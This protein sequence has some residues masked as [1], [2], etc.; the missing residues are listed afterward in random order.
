MANIKSR[1]SPKSPKKGHSATQTATT[2]SNA[3]DTITVM[4]NNLKLMTSD[5][6]K[7]SVEVKP[8][9]RIPNYFNFKAK[10]LRK[11]I[12]L[13]SDRGR[14]KK[15]YKEKLKLVND[16]LKSELLISGSDTE[17]STISTLSTTSKLPKKKHVHNNNDIGISDHNQSKNISNANQKFESNKNDK[18][19]KLKPRKEQKLNPKFQSQTSS[20]EQ[21]PLI[22][23]SVSLKNINL[24]NL[25]KSKPRKEQKINGKSQTQPDSIEQ[26]PAEKVSSS[27]ETNK[28]N[29]VAKSKPRKEQKANPKN[30]ASSIEDVPT[31]K[32]PK[33]IYKAVK[34]N[35]K[36]EKKNIPELQTQ[37]SSIR[38]PSEDIPGSLYE[39][40]HCSKTFAKKKLIERHMYGHL[41]LKPFKCSFCKKKFRYDINMQ[42]HVMRLHGTQDCDS[43]DEYRCDI[44]EEVF[45]FQETLNSHLKNHVRKANFF[46]CIVC[47]KKF[48][49]NYLLTEH[50]K[51]HLQNGRYQCPMCDMNYGIRNHFEAHLK[52]HS[53]IKDYIC[54]YCGKEFLR[55]NSMQRHVHV[56][57]SG[58]RFQCPICKK[59]LK[60]HLTE[61]MR[62]HDK[63]RPHECDVCGQR[64][65][66]STQLNVHM[67]SHTGAR[68]YPC[69]IC[70]RNFSHSNALMLHI[71]RH[72]GEKPFP[73]AMCPL[74]FS[75]LPHMK[76]HMKN[77][78]GKENAYKCEKCTQF[79][80]LKNDLERHIKTCAVG[81]KKSKRKRTQ[82]DQEDEEI[83]V[84]SVMTLS[85]MRYL[86]ALLL[87]I[88][89]TK[90]KLKYLGFNKRLID[91][92]LIES[93]EAMGIEPCMDESLTE[94]KRLKINIEMFI[95]G[96]VP[97]EELEK[98]KN[99][100][101]TTEEL[102]ELLTDEKKKQA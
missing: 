8:R 9:L 84:E 15:K 80:K 101:R 36:K 28:N 20:T 100:N 55:L 23:V 22:N 12:N 31:F 57:H 7:K 41:N 88:I 42:V 97:D 63:K 19:V 95:E 89:A 73:C 26:V 1:H 61:H 86:L 92:L 33:K 90:D 18:Q 67:R 17:K 21:V 96:T 27:L 51:T 5:A 13:V 94:F 38:D 68:P 76:A 48:A 49:E 85:R 29:K 37:P 10:A 30:Q 83:E 32:K 50:E 59:K 78:H 91:D 62:T 52:G 71:R 39:C 24:D 6:R 46:K 79:F 3:I 74:M 75:Q 93:L 53:K 58:H 66:Q 98:L 34:S 77:I 81:E 35:S 70:N 64:F 60:G 2:T 72:T 40:D 102:L 16:I 54:Q 43:L 69:R 47:E 82:D 11:D 4:K 14:I 99:E 65:T 45:M 56:C 25:V 44:C 87:T